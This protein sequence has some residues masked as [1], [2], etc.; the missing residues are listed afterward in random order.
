MAKADN[1]GGATA[2]FVARWK[3]SGAAE[4]AN[5]QP[6][7]TELCGVLGLESPH[8][9]TND[10]TRDEY[11]FER[12]VTFN[13]PD[14]STSTGRIDLYKRH[15]FVLEAKQGMAAEEPALFDLTPPPAAKRERAG[16]P[17]RYAALRDGAI[18]CSAHEGRPKHM[19]RPCRPRR[20]G[21][22]S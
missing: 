15:A 2:A 5:F 20:A 22:L 11:V 17:P 13:H 18:S 3:A 12:S 8:A 7:L 14:G 21:R 19:P 4:R 16:S 10:P 6:F 1:D 9:S